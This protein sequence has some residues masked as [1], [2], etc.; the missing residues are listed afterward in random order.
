[1][2]DIVSWPLIRF[3]SCDGSFFSVI[4]PD[5]GFMVVGFDW[6]DVRMD[7]IDVEVSRVGRVLWF[8][9]FEG[10]VSVFIGIFWIC[11]FVDN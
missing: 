3:D 11:V 9:P 4:F 1:V 8:L 2:S 5:V 6:L 10:C 7:A